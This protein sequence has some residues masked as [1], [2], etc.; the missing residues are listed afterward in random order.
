M[1]SWIFSCRFHTGCYGI[2]PKW[3]VHGVDLLLWSWDEQNDVRYNDCLLP[4]ESISCL[5]LL[6]P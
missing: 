4:I 1:L 3:K 2:R 6:N 5:R